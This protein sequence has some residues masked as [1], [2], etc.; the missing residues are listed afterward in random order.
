[1]ND[2]VIDLETERVS[3]GIVRGR[4]VTRDAREND[5]SVYGAF[6]AATGQPVPGRFDDAPESVIGDAVNAASAA[7]EQPVDD[8]VR[9]E[10][11]ARIAVVL[12]AHRNV[13]VDRC[14]RET[15]YETSRVEGE[16][17]RAAMQLDW[18]ADVTRSGSWRRSDHVAGDQQRQPIPRPDLRRLDV[19]VGPVAVFGACN[20][21]LAISV[22]G[23]DLVAAYAGGNPV[24]VKSHPG[25]V[26]TCE[27]LGR[28]VVRA[29]AD[30]GL[31][32]GWFAMIHGRSNHV[33]EQLVASENIAAV[34]FTGSPVGGRAVAAV[35]A[36]RDRP[37]PVFAELGSPNPVFITDAA[38]E[39]RVEA[40]AEGFLGSLRFGNGHMCTKPGVVWITEASMPRFESELRRRLADWKPLPMLNGSIAESF[41]AGVKRYEDSTEVERIA[42][43]DGEVDR[44][45]SDDGEAATIGPWH[46]GLRLYRTRFATASRGGWL[47]DET[48]GPMSLI[49]VCPDS[50]AMLDAA[51]QYRGSLTTTIHLD[52]SAD[53]DFAVR[54]LNHARR[55]A[56]RIIRNG[57]PTGMEIGWATQHG[58]PY[59]ASL[60]GRSTSVGFHSISRFVRPISLQNFDE[61]ETG[62]VGDTMPT[63]LTN[64]SSTQSHL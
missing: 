5:T 7:F 16:F 6:D 1:M 14:R 34:G 9:G 57:W 4:P 18:F 20:F 29:I 11:L 37:I 39:N 51:A 48:F 27:L 24:I 30:V 26:G 63:K 40:I 35:A 33:S 28:V 12:R 38:I 50:D 17:E 60:D 31:D 61:F 36:K 47:H 10:L 45:A 32:A 56:G 42:S 21:P 64:A 62:I 8:R 46:R 15:G 49:V 59:P 22:L 58:G 52:D 54:W 25:H 44:M 41:D 23:N 19:P 53:A 55:F 3:V 2:V 13:I 43:D